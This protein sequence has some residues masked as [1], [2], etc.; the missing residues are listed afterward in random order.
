M[1]ATTVYSFTP[2]RILSG[3]VL[4]VVGRLVQ[5]VFLMFRVCVRFRGSFYDGLLSHSRQDQVASTRGGMSIFADVDLIPACPRVC[6]EHGLRNT[7]AHGNRGLNDAEIGQ[8][9]PVKKK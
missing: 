7:A 1:L 8:T 2:C 9:L 4:A 5:N 3:S 6:Y